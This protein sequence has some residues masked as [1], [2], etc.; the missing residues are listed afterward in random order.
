M[1]LSRLLWFQTDHAYRTISFAEAFH[2]ATAGGG[3]FFGKTGAFL[4]GYSFDALVIDDS[5]FTRYRPL[6]L[7]ERLQKFIFA[8][9]DRQIA[10]RYRK[11]Q[12]LAKPLFD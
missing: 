2:M 3:A 12:A 4:P 1:R 7:F 6:S 10:V 8:G 9:D 11:G 5:A